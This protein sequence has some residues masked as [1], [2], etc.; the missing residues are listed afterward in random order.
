MHSTRPHLATE[1]IAY[2][3]QESH[4]LVTFFRSLGAVDGARFLFEPAR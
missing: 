4:A 3:L 1:N 2:A